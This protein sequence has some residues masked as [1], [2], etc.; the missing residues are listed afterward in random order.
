M[1]VIAIPAFNEE[2][3]IGSIVKTSLEFADK[4]IVCDDGSTD[5]TAHFAKQNG[6]QV[7]RHEKNLG[8]GAALSSLFNRCD[9]NNRW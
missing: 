6:A 7:I 2:N 3:T 9:D 5:K 1:N 8:Y 4:I